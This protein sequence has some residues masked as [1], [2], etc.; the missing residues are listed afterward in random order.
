[1]LMAHADPGVYVILVGFLGLCLA[2]LLG[3]V[4]GVVL[5]RRSNTQT[6]GRRI[7]MVA[8]AFAAVEIVVIA[9]SGVF[10]SS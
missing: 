3:L 2:T 4:A 1:M 7:L 8:T 5:M 6:L 9:F 10:H